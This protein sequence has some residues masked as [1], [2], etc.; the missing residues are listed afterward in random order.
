[1][2]VLPLRTFIQ[3]DGKSTVVKVWVFD[4]ACLPIE[5]QDE[6]QV[7][8]I[9]RAENVREAVRPVADQDG[10]GTDNNVQQDQ[11]EK[12]QNARWPAQKE[13]WL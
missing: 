10:R 6:E 7:P 11:N 8:V 9:P 13:N 12:L 3:I 4:P 2:R 1:M 5:M